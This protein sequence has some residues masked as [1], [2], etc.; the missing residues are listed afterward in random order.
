[1]N[2]GNHDL[3]PLDVL[4]EGCIGTP[5]GGTLFPYMIPLVVFCRCTESQGCQI[6][7][8]FLAQFG[9]PSCSA[10][11]AGASDWAG[12][13]WPN[14]ATLRLNADAAARNMNVH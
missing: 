10:L 6:G 3:T 2:E 9:N 5:L 4:G 14:L 8:D 13:I 11:R 7:L 12:K 1:M